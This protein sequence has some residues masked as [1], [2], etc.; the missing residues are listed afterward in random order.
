MKTHHAHMRNPIHRVARLSGVLA[1]VAALTMPLVAGCEDDPVVAADYPPFPPDG[2]FSVTGDGVVTIYW[3]SNQEGDL[4]GYTVYRGNE[5]LAGPYYALAD[6]P[7]NQTYYDDFDV[8]NGETWFYAVAA[9]DKNGHESD[10]SAEDV[11]DTP[12]PAG[13]DL[14]LVELGQDPLHAGYDFSSL[15]NTSQSAAL[16]TTDIY[17]ENQAG[18]QYIVCADPGVDIQDYG[19]IPLDGADYAPAPSEGGW[20]P[21]KKA[22]AVAGHSYF[23][24]ILTGGQYN[25][26]KFYVDGAPSTTVTLDWAYQP[27]TS[28]YGNRELLVFRGGT[29]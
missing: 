22:E 25:Y 11:F 1:A 7:A 12:R 2:V 27:S 4:A 19:L 23:V 16:G 29:R 24:R 6:V 21:S 8:N 3:N 28:Y 13:D 17:F 18:V 10:L 5:D 20:A 9:V 14:V 26:A 15:S